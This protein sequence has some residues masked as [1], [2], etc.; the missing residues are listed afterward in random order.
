L[1]TSFFIA[2]SSNVLSSFKRVFNK[3]GEIFS[4]RC[5]HCLNVAGPLCK[6]QIIPNA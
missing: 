4:Q 5:C 6:F 2:I 1:V 3:V